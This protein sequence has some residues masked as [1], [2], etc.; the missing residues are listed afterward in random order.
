MVLCILT[1]LCPLPH[2]KPKTAEVRTVGTPSP[3]H[4]AAFWSLP[5]SFL[6]QGVPGGPWGQALQAAGVL[7]GE[8]HIV[9]REQRGSQQG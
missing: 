3:C 4:S 9:C 2:I 8:E 7:G 1:L 5:S 6:S